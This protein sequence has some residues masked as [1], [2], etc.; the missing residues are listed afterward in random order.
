MMKF[1]PH[2]RFPPERL[3]LG[4]GILVPSLDVWTNQLSKFGEFVWTFFYQI[5]VYLEIFP[6]LSGYREEVSEW[7]TTQKVTDMS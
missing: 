6:P 2:S 5:T 1:I 3:A 7:N 4:D